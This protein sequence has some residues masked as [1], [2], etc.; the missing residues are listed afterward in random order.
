MKYYVW[1][2]VWPFFIT[3]CQPF[4]QEEAPVNLIPVI[5]IDS[6]A[7]N[8]R[9]SVGEEIEIK[10]TANDEA[11][12]QR[13]EL[14][15]N[16]ELVQ[17]D[18]P[19]IVTGQRTFTVLQ[20]WLPTEA[21]T[22]ELHVIAY[23]NQGA[24]SHPAA[25]VIDVLGEPSSLAVVHPTTIAIPT[26]VLPTEN[27]SAAIVSESIPTEIAI[28]DSE[29]IAIVPQAPPTDS[30]T[31]EAT[32]ENPIIPQAT[33]I[34]ITLPT[35]VSEPMTMTLPAAT[36]E[37][38]SITLPATVPEPTSITLPTAVPEPTPITLPTAASEPVNNMPAAAAIPVVEGRLVATVPL[39]IYDAPDSANEAIGT[40]NP[41]DVVI[42]IARNE[43]GNWIKIVYNADNREGW[44]LMEQFVWQ[45]DIQALAVH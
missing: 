2:L 40:L 14:Y 41:N 42:G 15:V 6:P 43:S 26:E 25:I 13:V 1:L 10:S 9:I 35:T 7:S 33:P 5:Q 4:W 11:F 16:G 24:V 37:P 3:A 21:Q 29:P 19:P 20:R 45:G 18:L 30:V 34:T 36:S 38:T 39:N 23:D 31:S 28:T 32:P 12:V 8:A 44:V 27:E 22:V 17:K